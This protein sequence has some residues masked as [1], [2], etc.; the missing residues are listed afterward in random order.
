MSDA[1]THSKFYDYVKAR[2]LGDYVSPGAPDG[3]RRK[4]LERRKALITQTETDFPEVKELY[5]RMRG[6]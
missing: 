4:I 2:K 5:E 1:L 6:Q 3:W